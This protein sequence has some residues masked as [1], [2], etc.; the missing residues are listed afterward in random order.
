M[1]IIIQPEAKFSSITGSSKSCGYYFHYGYVAGLTSDVEYEDHRVH[2][3]IAEAYPP[4]SMLCA[5]GWKRRLYFLAGFYQGRA[6]RREIMSRPPPENP[7]LELVLM[8]V[9]QKREGEA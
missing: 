5:L 6:R 1:S 9:A 2:R 4:Y 7:M 8:A 3:Q